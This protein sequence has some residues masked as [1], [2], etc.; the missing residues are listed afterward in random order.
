VNPANPQP[1]PP[2]A[3]PEMVRRG[4]ALPV[5]QPRLTIAL[6]VVTGLVYVAQVAGEYLLGG[7]VVAALGM[8]SNA[9]I[10]AGQYWRLVTPIFIHANLLHLFVN[11]YSLYVIGPPVEA[12]FGYARFLLIYFLSGIAGVVLSF[13]LSPNPSVGASGAIFGLVG[14]LTEYLFR[15][16]KRFGQFGRQRLMNLVG[17]IA[18]NLF[19]GLSSRQ[20]DNWGHLGGLAGGAL[21]G[22][23]IGPEF[24]IADEFTGQPHV[25]DRNP[26]SR[27]W[28]A[29]VAFAL[30]LAAAVSVIISLGT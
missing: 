30:G 7:D 13:A 27:R 21:L 22:W 26:L 28:F 16:R 4:L 5:V 19:L 11:C 3:G 20:I 2:P 8:K 29:A 14:A 12:P 10:A 25:V 9:A 17:I 24:E 15:H 6:V 1:T 23:L 18:L